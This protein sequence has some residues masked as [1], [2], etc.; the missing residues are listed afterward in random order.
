MNTEAPTIPIQAQLSPV[1]LQMSNDLIHAQSGL[2]EK[3]DF[4]D[5]F[6]KQ[7]AQEVIFVN[8]LNFQT[9]L[10]VA[11]RWK[12]TVNRPLSRFWKPD[13]SPGS[14][15]DRNGKKS[16]LAGTKTF[17]ILYWKLWH[18]FFET[19]NLLEF[20][21]KFCTEWASMRARPFLIPR[22]FQTFSLKIGFK[23]SPVW[24]FSMLG[25]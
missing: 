5:L 16:R 2:Q 23:R 25:P 24:Q 1:Y 9:V 6:H 21:W 14:V 12:L 7:W 13:V 10:F 22:I 17:G 18:L 20:V 3:P 4:E 19:E 15:N 11:S 8:S